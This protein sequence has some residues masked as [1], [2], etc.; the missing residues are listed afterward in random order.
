MVHVVLDV[1]DVL[2]NRPIPTVSI[3]VPEDLVTNPDPQ[4]VVSLVADEAAKSL[5]LDFK[6]VQDGLMDMMK[7][8]L[9]ESE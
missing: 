6:E 5:G 2:F 1:P 4:L 8:K 7:K 3:Q 9:E